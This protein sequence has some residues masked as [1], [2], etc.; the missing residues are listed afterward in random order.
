VARNGL[1]EDG[2]HAEFLA[3]GQRGEDAALGDAEHRLLRRLAQRVQ[4]GIAVAGD[5]ERRILLFLF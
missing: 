3:Q 2:D 1:L 4:A 5:H